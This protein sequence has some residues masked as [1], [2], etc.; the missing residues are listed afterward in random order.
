MQLIK[1]KEDIDYTEVVKDTYSLVRSTLG[2]TARIINIWDILKLTLGINEFEILM[3]EMYNNAS[4]ES[5][6]VNKQIDWMEGRDVDFHEIYEA[7]LTVGDFTSEEKRLMI[8][9]RL[10]EILWGI[11]LA[12]CNPELNF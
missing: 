8:N 12:I 5:Y 11:F 9:R 7:V 1:N 6:L 2:Y 10:E 4:F 3:P